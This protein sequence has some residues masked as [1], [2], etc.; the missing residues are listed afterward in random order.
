[1]KPEELRIALF[2]GNYNYVRD[3]ANQA[4]NRLV[5]YPAAPGRPGPGLFADHRHAGLSADRRPGQRAVGADS[6]PRRNIG[7]PIACRPSVRRDLEAFAPNIVHVAAPDIVAHRAVTW[8]TPARHPGRIVGPHP[9]RHLPPILWA[10]VPRAGRSRDHPPLLSPLRRDRRSG[11]IHRGDPSRAADEQGYFDLGPRRR[12]RPVQPGAP[13]PGMAPRR[14]ASATTRW[15]SASLAGWCWKRGSTFSPTR[16]MRRAT[17][18]CRFEVVAIGDGPARDYFQERLPDAIF[19]GQLTGDEL[20]TALASTDVFLNPSITETFGNVTLEA[21]ACG[22]A[23]RRGGRVGRDQ[24]GP[25][26]RDRQAVRSRATSTASPKRWPIISAI[27]P[28]APGMARQGW[29]SPRRWT[30]TKSTPP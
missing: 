25:G 12:P 23:G 9:V 5:G 20:A 4:L 22:P 13:Q 16:S 3:G 28:C 1:M 6:G 18:A 11:G 19:T 8:A 17:R 7:W 10:A 2:S 27:P 14:T 30:G 26:W 21:M 15:S 24:P 29:N